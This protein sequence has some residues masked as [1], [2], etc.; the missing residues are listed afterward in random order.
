M[1]FLSVV[2]ITFNE[3]KNI[4]RCLESVQSV[5]D[6]VI[7]VDSLSTDGTKRICNEFGVRFIEQA[8]LGYIEQKNFALDQA[9][10]DL[11]LSLDADE[12]IDEVLKGA[13]LRVKQ[14]GVAAD[15][16]IMSR[17]SNYCGKW[18]RHGTWYPDRKLRLF[19][20]QKARWGGVNPHDKI[21]LGAGARTGRLGGYFTLFLL[22]FFRTYCAAQ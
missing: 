1:S 16:Y 11:V 6:E 12:A 2:I 22:Y 10:H 4:K 21:V 9:S 7:V 18:I 8:F 5:A 17:C 13:I 14:E 19:N 3:E 20:R 15:G